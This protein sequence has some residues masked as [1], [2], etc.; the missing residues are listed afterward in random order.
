MKKSLAVNGEIYNHKELRAGLKDQTPFRTASD[1]EVIVHLYDEVGVDVASML[2]GDFAFVI[3]DEKTGEVYAARDPIGVNS[4]YWG[5]GLDGSTWFSSE[6]KPLV[7]AVR[8]HGS[9]PVAK[10][11]S[12]WSI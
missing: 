1:C 11:P 2:D 9:N 6:A 5:I 8:G 4:L 7:H 3:M 12:G 10:S